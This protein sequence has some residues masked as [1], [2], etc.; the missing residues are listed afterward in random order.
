MLKVHESGATMEHHVTQISRD[1]L[2]DLRDAFNKIGSFPLRHTNTLA[3]HNTPA[4]T[5]APGHVMAAPAR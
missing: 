4:G 2:E 1:D 3:G 5:Q